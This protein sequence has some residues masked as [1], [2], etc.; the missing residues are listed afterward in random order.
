MSFTHGDADAPLQIVGDAPGQAR[1][2]SHLPALAPRPSPRPNSTSPPSNIACANWPSSIPACASCWPTT[3]ASSQR[4][5]SSSTKA[6]SPAFVRYLDRT[7][8]AVLPEP[9]MIHG[10][11]DGIT[12]DC[13]LWWNDSYHENVAVLHQQHSAARRRHA[14]G[15]LPRRA[16]ARGQQLCQRKRHRQEGEGGSSPATTRARRSTC[17]LSVK[18]PDPKFSSQTK[19]KLVSSEV[20][21]VVEGLV[22]EQLGAWFEEHP[23]EARSIVG[24]V[25]EAAAA[26]EAA[27]KARELTRRKG[28]LDIAGLPGKLAECQERDP[29]A[30]RNL[31]RRGRL[32]RRLRQAGA[33]PREPGGAALARQDPQRR[34]RALR[35]DAVLRRDRHADHGAGH[36]HRPRGVQHRE[37]ALPQDHHHDRRRRRRRP[38]PHPAAHL[39]LPADA[40]S[41]RARPSLYRPAAALQG[42]ARFLR[43]ISQGRARRWRTI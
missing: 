36:R 26:R 14:S 42:E 16:D 33:Q 12:V 6:A 3:A 15:G 23:G 41:D 21:P 8:Q 27:R 32:G 38:Y 30:I 24:K 20:R 22:N 19:D 1:H 39:L 29:G 43:A 35:Q 37:A 17:V 11:K 25:V 10:E 5:S 2:R 28:A 7:K 34:A 4:R 18:V 13:A 40:G 9:I 31:H